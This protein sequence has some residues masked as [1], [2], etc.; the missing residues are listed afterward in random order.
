[1]DLAPH[2]KLFSGEWRQIGL[3]MCVG[4][5]TGGP[6]VHRL[7][8]RQFKLTGAGERRTKD[9]ESFLS[10]VMNLPPG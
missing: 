6:L 3:Q 8:W 2:G 9:G 4:S 7:D 1:M 10:L 5:G